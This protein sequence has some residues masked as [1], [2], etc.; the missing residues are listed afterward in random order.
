M[1][2]ASCHPELKHRAR[3]LCRAC[4]E[5][6]LY[7]EKIDKNREYRR[8][9]HASNPERH[10]GYDHKYRAANSDKERER[11]RKYRVENPEKVR[12]QSRKYY[13]ASTDEARARHLLLHRQR[14]AENPEK[15]R[16]RKRK[17]HANKPEVRRAI[18]QRRLASIKTSTANS[19]T[20]AQMKELL[21]LPCYYCG[22]TARE[23]DHYVPLSRGGS[24]TIDNLRPA[25]ITCNRSK[26]ANMPDEWVSR[27][28]HKTIHFEQNKI[29]LNYD[30]YIYNL[31]YAPDPP[32]PEPGEPTEPSDEEYE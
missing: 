7:A 32:R 21:S 14:Y 24:H 1:I 30:N 15:E 22:G 13:A 17:Y 29:M 18:S 16:E 20:A 5:R 9:R 2:L 4:Y 28:G 31:P 23:I 19:P 8:K 11:K 3:G 12:E 27:A 10:R 26:G 6:A 25:C